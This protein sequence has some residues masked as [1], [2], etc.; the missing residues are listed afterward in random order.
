MAKGKVKYR[1]AY[2]EKGNLVTLSPGRKVEGKFTCPNPECKL[3]M[4]PRQGDHNTWHFAHVGKECDYDHYLHTIAELRIQ[5]WY[6]KADKVSIR[7]PNE[8]LCPNHSNCKFYQEGYSCR[9]ESTDTD[10][11]K[12]YWPK[13]EIEKK[14]EIEGKTFFP[15]LLCK[16]K[17]NKGRPLFI[18]ICVTH[19]CEL[20]K[21]NTGV[22]IIEFFIKSEDDIDL[23]TKSII[24]P[25]DM[26]IYHNFQI[27]T[28]LGVRKDFGQVLNKVVV[29][30]NYKAGVNKTLCEDIEKRQGL[31]ELTVDSG[32]DL[33]E[34]YKYGSS[35]CIAQVLA[36]K[37]IPDYRSCYICVNCRKFGSYI[38]VAA[39]SDSSRRYCKGNDPRTCPHFKPDESIINK[40]IC[41]FEEFKRKYPV[42][43]Y[44]KQK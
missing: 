2:D 21:L 6:N 16:D 12:K 38:C 23:I 24:A 17:A 8:V 28:K 10:D 13:C 20:S 19:P 22:R 27:S 15:D 35:F 36:Y 1:S 37:Y 33:Q 43:L 26:V 42:D 32:L 31:L 9:K 30:D 34:L 18:E 25:S 5:E 41:A 4:I 29:F 11:L 39:P 44:I 14:Y 3:D 7:F 40:R